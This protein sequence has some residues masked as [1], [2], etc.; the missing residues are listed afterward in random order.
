MKSDYLIMTLFLATIVFLCVGYIFYKYK[1]NLDY[2]IKEL[3]VY[4]NDISAEVGYLV[5]D[6]QINHK[7]L[8]VDYLQW[9]FI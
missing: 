6:K 3:I 4:N 5:T 8:K 1:A 2:K 7:Y 9:K